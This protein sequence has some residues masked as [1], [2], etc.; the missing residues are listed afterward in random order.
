MLQGSSFRTPAVRAPSWGSSGTRRRWSPGIPP[1]VISS[2]PSSPPAG[3]N[4]LGSLS[5][6]RSQRASFMH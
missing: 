2:P 5:L 3:S 4:Q 6:T 1:R